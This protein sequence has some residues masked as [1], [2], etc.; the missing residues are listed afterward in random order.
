MRYAKIRKQDISNGPGNRISIF[1][2]GCNHHCKGCFN[3]ETWNFSDGHLWNRRIQTLFVE[4][5][6]DRDIA[7][8]SILGGEP[9][10]QGKEM[11]ELVKAIKEQYGDKKSIW[12]WTGYVYEDLDDLQKEI[13]SYIDVLVDGPFIES[14]KSL[15]RRF[16]GSLNQRIIDV[17]E[18]LNKGEVVLHNLF[19]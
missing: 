8:F 17:K 4:L 18:T 1:V 9:L 13:I 14:Q 11:L 19:G 2:Q 10:Q 3:P 12:M 5:A 15:N 6:N 16:K 7:G